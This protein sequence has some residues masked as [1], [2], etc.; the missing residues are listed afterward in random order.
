MKMIKKLL[1]AAVLTGLSSLSSATELEVSHWWTSGG[2]AAAVTELA[3]AFDASGDKWKD[4]AIAAGGGGAAAIIISRILGGDP[5]G[6]TQLNHGRDA[7]EL[8]KAGLLQDLTDV[9]EKENW[10][11]II[12]PSSLLDS[13]TFEGRI[14]C[15]PVNIHSP[16]WLWLSHKAFK[17]AG[18]PVPKNWSEFIAAAPAL[19]KA[20]KLPLAV[21]QQAWQSNLTFN[22]ITIAISGLEPWKKVYV[23]K[24]AEVAGGEEFKKVF[25]AADQARKISA[26]GK[27]QDWN[28]ATA[29]VIKG[30][31]GGQIM[32]DWAQGEF[33]LAGQVAGEDYTCLPGLGVTEMISTGG[34]AFYFPVLKDAEQTA[35]QKRLAALIIQKD[36]QVAFNLKKG[37]LPIRG[38]VDL[39]TANDCMKKGIKILAGNNVLPDLSQV[40]SADT[41]SDLEDLMVEFWNDPSMTTEE[42][43][44]RFVKV[45]ARAD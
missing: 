34:D 16:Q 15:A 6:A 11:E 22:A 21:G 9:A 39:E 38:D 26:K 20:G 17:D 5:M 25:E 10:R 12:R 43:Q 7:E 3:K 19:D 8:I 32:G 14:Y 18:I 29:M 40:I 23:D 44:E 28:A 33:Q 24:N 37:S 27:M 36:T 35:A 45:I 42:A 31:A 41:M 30:D 4:S 1:A 2:E 13:C